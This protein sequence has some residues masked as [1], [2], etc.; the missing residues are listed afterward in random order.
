MEIKQVKEDLK[1]L[2][3]TVHL[4]DTLIRTKNA[5]AYRIK[6][7]NEMGKG[8]KASELA[9]MIEQMQIER[10]LKGAIELQNK[11]SEAIA[12]LGVV[13]KTIVLE[14]YINGLTAWKIGNKLGYSEEAIRKHLAKALAQI[15]KAI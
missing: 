11:Y 7:L 14:Y 15:A 9:A 8:E 13:D 10:C 1:E 4:I 5:Y 3:K 6:E 12:T 2:K